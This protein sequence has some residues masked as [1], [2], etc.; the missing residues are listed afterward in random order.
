MSAGYYRELDALIYFGLKTLLTFVLP[1]LYVIT[2]LIFRSGMTFISILAI[3]VFMSC[4]GLDFN[5][6]MQQLGQ[7]VLPVFDSLVFF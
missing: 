5:P 7:N 1:I 6:S 2:T 4:L 3:A